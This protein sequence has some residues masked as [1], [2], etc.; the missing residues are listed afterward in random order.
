MIVTAILPLC[1]LQ[2][3]SRFRLVLC[4]IMNDWKVSEQ[5][6]NIIEFEWMNGCDLITAQTI[7]I[8][9]LTV[10]SGLAWL[11]AVH[12]CAIVV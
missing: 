11:G 2:T 1:S 7:T 6:N 3:V 4:M 12:Q 8:T 5:Y 10:Y 9:I